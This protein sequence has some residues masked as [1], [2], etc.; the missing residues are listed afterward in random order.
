MVQAHHTRTLTVLKLSRDRTKLRPISKTV[1]PPSTLDAS[2]NRP[3]S[4]WKSGSGGAG[5]K[6]VGHHDGEGARPLP[7]IFAACRG[8]RT[9]ACCVAV[10]AARMVRVYIYVQSGAN[11]SCWHGVRMMHT[12]AYNT[13]AYG[14]SDEKFPPFA[15]THAHTQMSVRIAHGEYIYGCTQIVLYPSSC[16][17]RLP[18]RDTS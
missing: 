1:T 12:G 16:P 7:R 9:R 17:I 2:W 6:G 15:P 8:V 11:R 14:H 5:A 3:R 4:L 10:H 18:A 13:N